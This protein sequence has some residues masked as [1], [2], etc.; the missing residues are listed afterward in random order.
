[1]D[2]YQLSDLEERELIPGFHGRLVHSEKMT[3]VYW[4]IEEGAVLPAHSHPHEQVAHTFTGEFELTIE[5]ET[6]LLTQD[7]IA[8]I[9]G[10]AQHWGKALTACKIMDAFQPVREDYR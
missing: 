4:R 7:S 10:N 5:G 8:V 6:Q 3:F 9:P 1:M 2:I